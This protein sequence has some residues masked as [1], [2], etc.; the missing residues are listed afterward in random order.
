M[1]A[2]P[3]A[4]KGSFDKVFRIALAEKEKAVLS[5]VDPEI[6]AATDV[7]K[8]I[9]PL[10]DGIFFCLTWLNKFFGNFGVSIIILSCF[11]K[12]LFLPL[13][14]SN[15]PEKFFGICKSS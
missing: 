4:P 6:V 9:E 1:A 10:R 15:A 11:T 8:W 14:G 12:C 7:S 13:W 5:T 2:A 3:L